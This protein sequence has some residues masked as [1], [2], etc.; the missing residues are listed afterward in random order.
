MAASQ[1][2]RTTLP[3][4][5]AI[6]AFGLWTGCESIKQAGRSISTA[7][8]EAF[9]KSDKASVPKSGDNYPSGTAASAAIDAES[10]AGGAIEIEIIGSVEGLEG[11]VA[12][13]P[14]FKSKDYELF[15]DSMSFARIQA[16]GSRVRAVFNGNVGPEYSEIS[17]FACSRDGKRWGYVAKTATEEHVIIDGDVVESVSMEDATIAMLPAGRLFKSSRDTV[18]AKSQLLEQWGRIRFS[19][20]GSSYVY[21]VAPPGPRDLGRTVILNGTKLPPVSSLGMLRFT[22][23]GR[24]VYFE[25]SENDQGRNGFSRRY[26]IDGQAGPDLQDTHDLQVYSSA[27]AERLVYEATFK[28]DD[29][30]ARKIFIDNEVALDL[31]SPPYSEFE[32]LYG[33]MEITLADDLSAIGVMRRWQ[34]EDRASKAELWVNGEKI[35][36]LFTKGSPVSKCFLGPNGR[37]VYHRAD[38]QVVVDGKAHRD[39]RHLDAAVFAAGSAGVMYAASAAPGVFVVNEKQQEVGPFRSV[40]DL[41]ISPDGRV[42]SFVT[43]R[44]ELYVNGKKI[45]TNAHRS[46][47]LFSADWKC[48]YATPNRSEAQAAHVA[49]RSVGLTV[50]ERPDWGSSAIAVSADG[51]H[52]AKFETKRVKGSRETYLQLV[53]NDNVVGGNFSG[54]YAVRFEPD[55]TLRFMALQGTSIVRGSYRPE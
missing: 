49:A 31:A 3:V 11:K 26:V 2:P 32:G 34:D 30:E 53:V 40:R 6:L 33:S 43:G 25:A 8:N 7:A 37:V 10:S 1:I 48:L 50:V 44:D 28:V 12:V 41:T 51:S 16:V 21:V 23:G 14:R 22:P 27:S 52:V 38:G 35:D 42:C 36:D 19:P 45:A 4:A 29:R 9:R 24:L 17:S 47:D 55:D 20:D 5:L 18:A 15:L 46:S 39:Y 13:N 54:L